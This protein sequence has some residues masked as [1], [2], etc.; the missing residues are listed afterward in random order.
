VRAFE[1]IRKRVPKITQEQAA[2]LIRPNWQNADG[3]ELTEDQASSWAWRW[4]V[5]LE[6]EPTM[7]P[8]R[9]KRPIRPTAEHL[10]HFTWLERD[11]VRRTTDAVPVR[12]RLD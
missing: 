8:R 10:D 5:H 2:V 11:W 6:W 9:R 12:R 7:P 3:S 4:W 1:P